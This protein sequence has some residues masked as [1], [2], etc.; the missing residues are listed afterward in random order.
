MD[1]KEELLTP[2]QVAELLKLSPSYIYK[3]IRTGEMPAL[4]F[5]RS[6]R[7]RIGDLIW[8][9][10]EKAPASLAQGVLQALEESQAIHEESE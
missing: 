6:V 5:G 4:R 9:L 7:V 8:Y 1:E 3:I 2:H 10:H